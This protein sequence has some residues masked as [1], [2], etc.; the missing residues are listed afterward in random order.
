MEHILEIEKSS[1]DS[2][3]LSHEDK[4]QEPKQWP[5]LFWLYLKTLG[6]YHSAP[7]VTIRRCNQCK[8]Q[9][10]ENFAS[11]SS[12]ISPCEIC[13]SFLWDH[14]GRVKNLK[15][16]EIGASRLNHRGSTATSIIWLVIILASVAYLFVLNVMRY[17]ENKDD[18]VEFI[19]TMS[20]QLLLLIP[21]L[22]STICMFYTTFPDIAPGRWAAAM[23]P[24]Y[25]VQ[26][27]RWVDM[28]RSRA[29]GY[30]MLFAS[31]FFIA[32]QCS[33]TTTIYN[34][35][36]TKRLDFRF[37]SYFTLIVNMFNYVGFAYIAYL[38]RRS[39][40]K[41]VRLLAQFVNQR[42]EDIDICR[43][44]LA[45]TFDSFHTF[46]EFTSG[47]MSLNIVLATLSILLEL[48]SWIATT[49]PLQYFRYVRLAFLLAC[50]ILPIQALGNVSVDYL[51]GRMVRGI[52]RLR[53]KEKEH[54]YDKIMQFL[55]EQ[56]PGDRPWQAVM[57]FMLS[58]TAVF[59]GIQFR[60]LSSKTIN[61]ATS[62]SSLNWNNTNLL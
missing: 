33:T 4:E 13:E 9:G 57:A 7:L 25:L 5:F 40:E 21:P 32:L 62:F 50:F 22:A 19:A 38:L 49:G 45:E 52:S 23:S 56:K 20:I 14:T 39:F 12:F 29:T 18:L 31:L 35:K 28:R 54:S 36:G 58:T 43:L 60:V 1:E 11:I 6:L 55:M 61:S 24:L 53:R 3:F 30:F 8:D 37:F 10:L 41:E 44:R 34:Y 2:L 17:N 15:D 59:A 26:R 27:L 48:H 42:I 47:W 46:R 16:E 51:W